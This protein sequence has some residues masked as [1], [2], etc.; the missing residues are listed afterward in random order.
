MS[1]GDSYGKSAYMLIYER[2][3]KNDIREVVKHATDTTPEE[4]QK[5]PYREIMPVVPDWVK[6]M[7]QKNNFELMIDR[8]V[9]DKQ[10]F[11][12]AKLVLKHISGDL[13]MTS[14]RYDLDYYKHFRRMNEV[15]LKIAHKVCFDFLTHYQDN[16]V[17]TFLSSYIHTIFNSSES[18]VSFTRRGDQPSIITQW[19]ETVLLEDQGA[20]FFDIMFNCP[21]PVARKNCGEIVTKGINAGFRILQVMEMKAEDSTHPKV[22]RLRKALYGFL[23]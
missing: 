3:T 1:Y 16:N 4:V 9:F 7:V 23:D 11:V 20:S 21:S 15:A 17:L 22:E 5:I 6:E 2:K 18:Y 19:I 12:L 14:H 8:Q 13:A 10:F